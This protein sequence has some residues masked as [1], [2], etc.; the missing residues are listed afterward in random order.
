[1]PLGIFLAAVPSGASGQQNCQID[2]AQ[3]LFGQQPR[4]SATVKSLLEACVAAGSKDYR[5]YM[6]LG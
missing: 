6:L 2:E 5:T 4:P 1:M 3:R